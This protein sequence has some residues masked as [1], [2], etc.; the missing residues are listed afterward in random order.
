MDI[1]IVTVNENR[2]GFNV[3]SITGREKYITWDWMAVRSNVVMKV[4][5]VK[6]SFL[7]KV[8]GCYGE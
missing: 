1:V 4:F 8:W 6:H 2:K 7:I 5:E 3:E